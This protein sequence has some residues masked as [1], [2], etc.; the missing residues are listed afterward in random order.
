MTWA[1]QFNIYIYI[2]IYIYSYTYKVKVHPRTGHE[3]PERELYSFTLSST[4]ALDGG[5]VVNATPRP[6]YPR[7]RR[8]NHCI[9][10]WV[11]SGSVWRGAEDLAPTGIR[12]LDR[13]ARSESLYWLS[14]P[15]SLYIY[16]Y[17]YI[18]IIF[19]Y[20]CHRFLPFFLW[21]RRPTDSQCGGLL[22]HPIRKTHTH[23]R[24]Q[25][26]IHMRTPMDKELARRSGLYLTTQSGIRTR[27]L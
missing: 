3:V 20:K 22:L 24:T 5:W 9:G 12:S 19:V 18:H 4:S 23:V 26:H 10:G 11:D 16:I 15:G 7:E 6:L 14:Y 2:Y 8:G 1:L 17:I 25:K 27:I 21:S 13:P